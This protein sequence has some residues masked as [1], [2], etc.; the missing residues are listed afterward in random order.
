MNTDNIEM[1]GE[2]LRV[3]LETGFVLREASRLEDAE[4]VFCGCAELVP[5]SEV[6]LVG[7]ATVCLQK[8][9]FQRA[10]EI[11]REAINK[12]DSSAYARLHLGEAL[13]FNDQVAEATIELEGVAAANAGSTYAET[14]LR[15]LRVVGI[16]K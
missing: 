10:V 6:P 15:I 3:L 8:G 14:A 9:D 7:L 11:C 1:T 4:A 13:F 16:K 5:D 2:R 12:E